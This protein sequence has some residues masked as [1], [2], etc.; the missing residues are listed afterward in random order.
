MY[1]STSFQ[2]FLQNKPTK[3]QLDKLFITTKHFMLS[4]SVREN[5]SYFKQKN[6]KRKHFNKN[7]EYILIHKYEGSDMIPYMFLA[8]YLLKD[9]KIVK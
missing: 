4:D 2:N 9:L 6:I 3:L 7:C 5:Y 8:F 1:K